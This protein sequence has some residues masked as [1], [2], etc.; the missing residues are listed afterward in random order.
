MD[1]AIDLRRLEAREVGDQS[2]THTKTTSHQEPQSMDGYVCPALLQ[3][4]LDT[5]LPCYDPC[6]SLS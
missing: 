3:D 2:S 6:R 4:L 1:G 5:H